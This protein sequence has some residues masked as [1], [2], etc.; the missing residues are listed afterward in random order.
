[1]DGGTDAV[2]E[3][4]G[5]REAHGRGEA[6]GMGARWIGGIGLACERVGVSRDLT[7]LSHQDH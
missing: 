7:G 6:A 5:R 4:H 1:M 2:G 3:G